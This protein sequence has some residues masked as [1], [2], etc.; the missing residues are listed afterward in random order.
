MKGENQ[1]TLYAL[2]TNGSLEDVQNFVNSNGKTKPISPIEIIAE[3]ENQA[4]ER[5]DSN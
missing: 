3:S 5:E 1:E 2:L 4:K